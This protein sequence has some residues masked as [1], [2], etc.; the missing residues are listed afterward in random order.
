M[1]T[2]AQLVQL[3]DLS[4]HA[5]R[6]NRLHWRRRATYVANIISVAVVLLTTGVAMARVP[7]PEYSSY[8]TSHSWGSPEGDCQRLHQ[9]IEQQ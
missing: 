7:V 8:K 1:N 3:L 6:S 9:M 5:S 2:E 4:C